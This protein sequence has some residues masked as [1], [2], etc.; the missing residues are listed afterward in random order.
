M[1]DTKQSPVDSESVAR[2]RLGAALR[3]LQHNIVGRSV[4]P[5]ALDRMADQILACDEGIATLPVRMRPESSFL[6]FTAANDAPDGEVLEAGY[7]DRPYGGWSSPL[8][9][10]MTIVRRGDRVVTEVT[11]GAAHEGAPGRS[12]GG[13]VAALFDDLT[14][15]VLQI[16]ASPAYTGEL[17]VR[18]EA[19]VPLGV[20]LVAS[21]WMRERSGRKLFI[22]GEL[23]HGDKRLATV[24]TIYITVPGF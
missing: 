24:E 4:A 3:R 10:E 13:I 21:A 6:A 2:R 15:F 1:S 19:P 8:S 12:H 5:D 7:D 14:G 16:A 23:C 17:K 22:D 20:P 11:L 9:L 18:Y